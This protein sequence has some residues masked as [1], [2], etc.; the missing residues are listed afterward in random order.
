MFFV[1]VATGTNNQGNHTPDTAGDWTSTS[2]QYTTG[3]AVA[4]TRDWTIKFS[5]DATQPAHL[6]CFGTDFNQPLVLASP[7]TKRL[8]FVSSATFAAAGGAAAADAH[9]QNEAQTASLS[10][11]YRALLA[12]TTASATDASRFDLTG[13]PWVR[14][15]GTP[16]VATAA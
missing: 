15:D 12:T 2:A 11:S 13:A 7:T 3:D 1:P 14:L 8:A 5:T 6:Y 9:C 10:G 16:W 4:T